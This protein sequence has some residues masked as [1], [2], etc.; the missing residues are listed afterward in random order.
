M[1]LLLK[2]FRPAFFVSNETISPLSLGIIPK[3][4][5]FVAPAIRGR[6]LQNLYKL[7]E[8]CKEQPFI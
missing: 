8:L 3:I 2:E 5:N 7:E 1:K 4:S 6:I